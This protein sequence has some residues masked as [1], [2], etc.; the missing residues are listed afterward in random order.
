M[1]KHYNVSVIWSLVGSYDIEA[2]SEKEAED[3]AHQLPN[4]DNGE[5]LEG[6]FEIDNIKEEE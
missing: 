4:P 5:Y 3:I 2:K 6:S 1:K